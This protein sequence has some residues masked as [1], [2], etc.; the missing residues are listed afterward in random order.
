MLCNPKCVFKVPCPESLQDLHDSGANPPFQPSPHPKM[1]DIS[2]TAEGIDKLFVCLNP[3]KAAGPDK[4]K[5]VVLQILHKDLA[6]VG[7]RAEVFVSIFY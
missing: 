7:Q 6:P 1:P 2:I 5:P 4:F 3:H